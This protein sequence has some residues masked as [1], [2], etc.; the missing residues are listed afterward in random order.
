[1]RHFSINFTYLGN[2]YQAYVQKSRSHPIQFTVYNVYPAISSFP[3]RIVFFSN[4]DSDQLVCESFDTKYSDVI[5]VI[6]QAIF[7]TCDVQKIAI[8]Q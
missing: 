6:G 7:L 5:N 3:I 8:H 2:N 4:P 1:M